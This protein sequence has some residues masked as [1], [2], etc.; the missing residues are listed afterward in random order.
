MAVKKFESAEAFEEHKK[1]RLEDKSAS[2]GHL[3]CGGWTV[4]R[5]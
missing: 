3:Q 1:A 4:G 5:S 2:G